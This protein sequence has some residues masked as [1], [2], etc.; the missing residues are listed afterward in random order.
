VFESCAF[1]LPKTPRRKAVAKRPWRRQNR[2]IVVVQFCL[3]ELRGANSRNLNPSVRHRCLLER[4]TFAKP[5]RAA[6]EPAKHAAGA[7]RSLE[8]RVGDHKRRGLLSTARGGRLEGRFQVHSFCLQV[9]IQKNS[10]SHQF[11]KIQKWQ[12]QSGKGEGRAQNRS[13]NA[14]YCHNH[15]CTHRYHERPYTCERQHQHT[16]M[17]RGDGEKLAS[18][19]RTS[20]DS[21]VNRT[22][23]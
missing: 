18:G 19:V 11:S 17:K 7:T 12:V 5:Q 22:H 23:S 9:Q 13:V 16:D 2:S 4:T 15:T 21:L 10:L 8:S 14:D 20:R 6:T 3:F 1:A